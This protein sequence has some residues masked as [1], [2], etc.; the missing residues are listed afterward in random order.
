M[1]ASLPYDSSEVLQRQLADVRAEQEELQRKLSEAEAA[2]ASSSSASEEERKAAALA[3]AAQ[4]KQA[5]EAEKARQAA[6]LRAVEEAD[7]AAAAAEDAQTASLSAHLA[8]WENIE[9]S[10][11]G[12]QAA[13]CPDIRSQ[14]VACYE[15]HPSGLACADLVASFKA[16]TQG[17]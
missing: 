12:A 5:H 4:A 14:L 8:K 9:T 17:Q 1:K 11:G 16:C 15:Q 10:T 3:A 13:A 2:A 6:A 7:A